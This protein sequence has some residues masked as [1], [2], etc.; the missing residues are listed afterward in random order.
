MEKIKPVTRAHLE[1]VLHQDRTAR[2]LKLR[3][4]YCEFM[5]ATART[6][7]EGR[8]WAQSMNKRWQECVIAREL[9]VGGAA[10]VP[11]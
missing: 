1:A 11:L 5:S 3:A 6:A 9:G 8:M 2:G 10:N 4:E 7:H